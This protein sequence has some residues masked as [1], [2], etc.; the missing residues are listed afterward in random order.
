MSLIDDAAMLKSLAET[1]VTSGEKY[2]T[3]LTAR[4]RSGKC[5]ITSFDANKETKNGR[6]GTFL[7][8]RVLSV[9][10]GAENPKYSDQDTNEVGELV[11]KSF[12]LKEGN[13]QKRSAQNADLL[14]T[15][16]AVYESVTGKKTRAP[17]LT[18]DVELLKKALVALEQSEG[19][20]VDFVAR[21][22]DG[23]AVYHDL[24][25]VKN[26]KEQVV[27]N[28]ANLVS[29]APVTAFL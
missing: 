22:T 26:T 9:V 7:N 1:K 8:M 29:G 21:D 16:A 17:D 15:A 20:I 6:I 19:V 23:G 25:A 18:A 27:K 28:R 2:A 14:R 10:T 13:A 4:S 3:Y 24:N 5:V 11:C 12:F